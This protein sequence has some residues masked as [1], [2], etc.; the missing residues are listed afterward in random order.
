MS[1]CLPASWEPGAPE[2]GGSGIPGP[3]ASRNIIFNGSFPVLNPSVNT[4]S[5]KGGAERLGRPL[6]G[7]CERR[8]RL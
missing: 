6:G 4:A 2:L 3:V 5:R 8:D 1:P 7:Y